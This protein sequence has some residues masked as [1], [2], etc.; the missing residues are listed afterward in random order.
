MDIYESNKKLEKI[1]HFQNSALIITVV[2][3]IAVI[4]YCVLRSLPRIGDLLLGVPSLPLM[5]FWI[6]MLS[7]QLIPSV[8]LISSRSIRKLHPAVRFKA[9]L[10]Y[11]IYTWVV[12]FSGLFLYEVIEGIRDIF[13][14]VIPFIVS[15]MILVFIFWIF[16]RKYTKKSESMF[17]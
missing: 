2:F 5:I 6:I 1:K 9:I 10:H 4:T 13:V 8:L 11:I 16:Y 7:V 14:V 3:G 17:P 15:G 12:F